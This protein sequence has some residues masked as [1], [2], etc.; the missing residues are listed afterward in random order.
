MLNFTFQIQIKKFENFPEIL[1]NFS[2]NFST[3]LNK[4]HKIAFIG[5]WQI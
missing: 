1:A 3:N 2:A 4:N 5:L